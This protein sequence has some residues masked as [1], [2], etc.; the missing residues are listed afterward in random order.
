MVQ[1]AWELASAR[2]EDDRF[3]HDVTQRRVPYA[4]MTAALRV[5]EIVALERVPAAIL[6]LPYG[7][8]PDFTVL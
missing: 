1:A 2:R 7:P 8:V 6:V 4:A 3:P 5:G